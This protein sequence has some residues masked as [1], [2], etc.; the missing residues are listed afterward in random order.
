[1]AHN[2]P[3]VT[4]IPQRRRWA[5]HCAAAVMALAL[6]GLLLFCL[7][8]Q[9]KPAQMALPPRLLPIEVVDTTPR[10]DEELEPEV[11]DGH[12]VLEPDQPL[13]LAMA[14]LPGPDV[15][16][17]AIEHPPALAISPA[18]LPSPGLP[19]YAADAP[20][21]G[22]RAASSVASTDGRLAGPREA[23]SVVGPMLL[24]PPGLSSYYPYRARLRGIT[25]RSAIRLSVSASGRVT[26]V[27]VLDST[28]AG[29][30]DLAAKRVG[31]T[32]RFQPAMRDGRRVGATVSLDLVWRL[33]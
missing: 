28:P 7:A 11:P 23:G 14:P 15:P 13:V 26:G 2:L 29:V 19:V 12:T 18:P 24:Q 33:E 30:F 6:N 25:G 27:H 22:L 10:R 17:V 20:L 1:M 31:K 3:S 21:A 32:L 5:N 9:R 4:G 16:L 8:A